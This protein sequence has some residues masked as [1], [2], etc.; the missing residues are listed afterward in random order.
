MDRLRYVAFI[1]VAPSSRLR[2][3]WLLAHL[4]TENGP[5]SLT[6]D[7]S[8]LRRKDILRLGVHSCP[9]VPFFG[10]ALASR[11]RQNAYDVEKPA[12]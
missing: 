7:H 2:P 8:E 3:E 12:R 10:S 11:A 9:T 5:H 6:A 1:K 4:V